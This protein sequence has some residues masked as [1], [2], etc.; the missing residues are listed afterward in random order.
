MIAVRDLVVRYP[1]A[2]SN[3]VDGVS[4]VSSRGELTALAGPNGSGKSS[5]VRALLR[6]PLGSGSGRIGGKVEYRR[7]V[8]LED[9]ILV[10]HALRVRDL[11]APLHVP[12]AL[13][14]IVVLDRRAM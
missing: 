14:E 2:G 5:I 10:P 12:D 13:G 9:Q 3:A 11:V 4:F 8:L 7:E 1:G 6:R